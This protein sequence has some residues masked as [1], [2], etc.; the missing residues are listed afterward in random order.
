MPRELII[1]FLITAN[2]QTSLAIRQLRGELGQLPAELT[3]MRAAAAEV[4][5]MGAMGLFSLGMLAVGAQQ[6]ASALVSAQQMAAL[7]AVATW[8]VRCH[9]CSCE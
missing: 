5:A 7:A 4:Y 9:I 6:L 3:A 8:S 1:P 2:Y